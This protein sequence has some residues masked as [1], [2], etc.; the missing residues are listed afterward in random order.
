MLFPFLVFSVGGSEK[1]KQVRPLHGG[2]QWA[3]G[4]GLLCQSLHA[5]PV[6]PSGP[7]PC[8]HILDREEAGGRCA[9]NE[10]NVAGRVGFVPPHFPNFVIDVAVASATKDGHAQDRSS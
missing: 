7:S 10:M 5:S 9:L 1:L 6:P 2:E 8:T 4:N 3:E